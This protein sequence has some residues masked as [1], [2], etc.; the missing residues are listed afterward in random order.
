MEQIPQFIKD[1][2][3]SAVKM[4]DEKMDKLLG[5]SGWSTTRLMWMFA[6]TMA[7]LCASTTT[8]AGIAVYCQ[9]PLHT[10]DGI[11]WGACVAQWVNLFAFVAATKMKQSTNDRAVIISQAGGA[12]PDDDP[13]PPDTAVTEAVTASKTTTTTTPPKK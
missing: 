12:N 4:A 1:S 3:S 5:R 2:L 10:A 13:P 7:V 9:A 11:Y 6:G 8:I